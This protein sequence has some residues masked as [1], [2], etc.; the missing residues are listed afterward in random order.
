M[1]VE[2]TVALL[3]SLRLAWRFLLPEFKPPYTVDVILPQRLNEFGQEAVRRGDAMQKLCYSFARAFK[4]N[5]VEWLA[6]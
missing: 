1:G 4:P 2:Q 5:I 6:A 3:P